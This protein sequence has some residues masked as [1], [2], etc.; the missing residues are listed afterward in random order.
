MAGASMTARAAVVETAEWRSG[1]VVEWRVVEW[2]NGRGG[3]ARGSGRF[4]L[5]LPFR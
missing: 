3:L 5:F 1:G 2:Q 4:S